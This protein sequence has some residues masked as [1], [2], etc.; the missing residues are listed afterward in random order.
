MK[1][2]DDAILDVVTRKNSVLFAGVSSP[3]AGEGK[4]L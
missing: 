4:W 1:L 3:R 2:M